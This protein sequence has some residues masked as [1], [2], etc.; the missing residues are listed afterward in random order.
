MFAISFKYEQ[1]KVYTTLTDLKD[2]LSPAKAYFQAYYIK[3]EPDDYYKQNIKPILEKLAL[4]EF[5][6]AQPV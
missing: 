6:I 1:A 3:N 5:Y 2:D 4:N